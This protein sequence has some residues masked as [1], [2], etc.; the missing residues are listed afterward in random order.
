MTA[1]IFVVLTGQMPAHSPPSSPPLAAPLKCHSSPF[2]CF[3]AKPSSV[4]GG[5]SQMCLVYVL[6]LSRG[7][8]E[9]AT[10]RRGQAF[11]S[12]S[13]LPLARMS[14][15]AT[16]L[17]APSR[18]CFKR[19]SGSLTTFHSKTSTNRWHQSF[20]SATSPSVR[21]LTIFAGPPIRL[22]RPIQRLYCCLAPPDDRKSYA[23]WRSHV[24][25]AQHVHGCRDEDVRQGDRLPRDHVC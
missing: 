23:A 5:C 16:T 11:R 4:A 10:C 7:A 21:G 8:A 19:S 25:Y 17:S 20:S 13:T 1:L 22:C 15:P 14:S 12:D 3:E 18:H 6:F 9:N 2:I 24:S